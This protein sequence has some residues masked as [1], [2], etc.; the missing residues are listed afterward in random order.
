MDKLAKSISGKLKILRRHYAVRRTHKLLEPTS[1]LVCTDN[2]QKK[3][4]PADEP[5]QQEWATCGCSLDKME[6]KFGDIWQKVE[7]FFF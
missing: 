4:N 6:H 1:S 2:R 5:L 7:L 3:K